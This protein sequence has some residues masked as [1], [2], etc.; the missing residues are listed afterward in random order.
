M[1]PYIIIGAIVFFIFILLVAYC[2]FDKSWPPCER[3]RRNPI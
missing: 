1:V 3:F 2:L